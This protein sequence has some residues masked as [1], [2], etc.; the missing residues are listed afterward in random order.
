MEL[1]GHGFTEEARKK[2]AEKPDKTIQTRIEGP[3]CLFKNNLTNTCMFIVI[4]NACC[5]A[6]IL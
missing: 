3:G 1:I 2:G 6:K 4:L 5:F